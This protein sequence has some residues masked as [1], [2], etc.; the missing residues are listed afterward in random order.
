MHATLTLECDV[1]EGNVDSLRF[2]IASSREELEAA[3]RLVHVAYVRS[4]LERVKASGM[5]I[6]PYHLLPTTTVF[7]AKLG[8]QVVTTL[9]LVLDG[10]RG[11]PMEAMYAEQVAQWRSEGLKLAEVTCLADRR[12]DFRRFLPS[13]CRLTRLMA[14]FARLQGVDQLLAAVHP[15]H[16]R[17]YER[18]LGF[19][20]AGGMQQCPYVQNR[21]A[22]AVSLNFADARREGNPC[23]DRY[24]G[25][26]IPAEHL[27]PHVL[28]RDDRR[29][30]DHQMDACFKAAC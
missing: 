18:I 9:T 24:F 13:F 19:K 8:E 2:K 3:F 7:V 22:T 23:Y 12:R 30:F 10:D 27:L 21:P 14:Q 15:K 25:E 16:A 28:S 6:T 5:R 26:P 4:G 17:F 11:L 29:H 20:S 1:P